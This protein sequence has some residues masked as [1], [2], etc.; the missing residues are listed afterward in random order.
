[1]QA[2]EGSSPEQNR[3]ALI[4][5]Q[6]HH[7]SEPTH[8]SKCR[9]TAWCCIVAERITHRS[10]RGTPVLLLLALSNVGMMLFSL[11]VMSCK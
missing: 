1:M 9:M 8:E 3:H 6:K 11:G 5:F 2:Q 4:K 10:D 7:S